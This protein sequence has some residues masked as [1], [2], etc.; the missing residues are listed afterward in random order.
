MNWVRVARLVVS[1][2]G[3]VAVGHAQRGLRSL[4]EAGIEAHLFSEI[5]QNPTTDDVDAGVRWHVDT[6]P[7]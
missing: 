7:N 2:P 5:Q 1:D 3:V 6:S 4:R